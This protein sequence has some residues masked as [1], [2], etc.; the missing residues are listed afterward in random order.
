[1]TEV[2]HHLLEVAVADHLLDRQHLLGFL[3]PGVVGLEVV[4]VVAVGLRAVVVVGA[5]DHRLALNRDYLHCHSVQHP[6]LL[7]LL[8]PKSPCLSPSL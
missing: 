8:L 7:L 1:V 5:A 2:D 3:V 6:L 4:V